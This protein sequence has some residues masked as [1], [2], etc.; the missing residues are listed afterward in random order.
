MKC[1]VRVVAL[2]TFTKQGYFMTHERNHFNENIAGNALLGVL[3]VG[4]GVS[5]SAPCFTIEA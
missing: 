4:R 5:I 3:F 1:L 2:S